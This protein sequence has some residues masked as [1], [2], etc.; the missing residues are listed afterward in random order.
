MLGLW[1]L[2][3]VV[4]WHTRGW[5]DWLG[6]DYACFW[7]ST[8]AWLHDGPAAA[9]DMA[10]VTRHAHGLIPYMHDIA[11]STRGYVIAAA[12]YPP[13]FFL[14]FTPFAALPP[15]AGYALWSAVNLGLVVYVVADIARGL[16]PRVRWQLV[17]LCLAFLPVTDGLI[18]GQAMGL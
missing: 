10:A 5:F 13:A 1:G 4:N 11:I 8:Q 15:V 9:Y 17:L 3:L 12:P 6:I 18:L 2:A 7:S 14:M 16:P